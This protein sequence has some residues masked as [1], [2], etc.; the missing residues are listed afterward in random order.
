VLKIT[1]H[2]GKGRRR[3]IKLEGELLE[4][5]VEAVRDACTR[6]N[7]RSKPVVLDLKAVTYADGPG[8]QLLR[9]LLGEG[10]EI[11]ACSSFI[12]ELL[13]MEE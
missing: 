12:A 1:Q 6:R 10:I 4:P 9:E 5:W 11:A 7:R 3:V 13:D 8:A 2:S